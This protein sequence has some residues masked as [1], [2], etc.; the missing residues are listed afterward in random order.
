MVCVQFVGSN[1]L[2]A[3]AC[4]FPA[5]RSGDST[6]RQFCSMQVKLAVSSAKPSNRISPPLKS[7]KHAQVTRKTCYIKL[8]VQNIILSRYSNYKRSSTN[9]IR[10][11]NTRV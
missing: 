11:Y 7:V 10:N 3:K 4:G 9:L 2:A 8:N 1:V 6:V 5:V